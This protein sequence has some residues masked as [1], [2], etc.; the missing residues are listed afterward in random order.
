MNIRNSL[1]EPYVET[2][3]YNPADDKFVDLYV[4]LNE[5]PLG[6]KGY[7]I[8]YNPNNNWFALCALGSDN[9][10]VFLGY[11]DTFLDAF[12]GM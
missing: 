6:K 1:I 7:Q 5:D 9:H 2:Y 3:E 8:A 4:V 11:Y 12:E 10:K